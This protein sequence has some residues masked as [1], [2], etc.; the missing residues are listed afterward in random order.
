MNVEP[1]PNREATAR[2]RVQQYVEVPRCGAHVRGGQ[3]VRDQ[4][5][6]G[7][8]AGMYLV[9]GDIVWLCT[10]HARMAMRDGWRRFAPKAGTP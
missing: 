5:Y 6:A 4:R 2:V 10:Q 9:G 7:P 1:K 3:C 8:D